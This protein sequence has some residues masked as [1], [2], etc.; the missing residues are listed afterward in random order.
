MGDRLDKQRQNLLAQFDNLETTVA[1]L[2][3]N[4]NALSSLQLLP[5]LTSTT[6]S[7]A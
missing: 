7:S 2:K 4:L 5:P 3:N 6:T 1:G